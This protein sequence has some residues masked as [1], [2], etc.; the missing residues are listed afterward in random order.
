MRIVDERVRTAEIQDGAVLNAK[1]GA[2]A[3]IVY[4][5]LNL[6]TSI[7]TGDIAAGAVTEPK[8]E[9]ATSN[10][11][12][13]Y[14][15]ARFIYDWNTDGG[16][17]GSIPFRGDALPAKSIIKG[18]R[19]YV[20][21]ALTGAGGTTAGIT[22]VG[23]DDIVPDAAVAGAPWNAATTERAITPVDTLISDVVWAAGG[24]PNL[25]VTTHNL[26]DGAIDLWLEYIVND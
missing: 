9:P 4:S 21:R 17:A 14:R 10:K 13:A 2:T 24:I 12:N 22:A 26:T 25:V 16:V 7:A 18:G 1:V 3:A 19:M 15:V 5:K 6:A 11:R 20:I 8:L 23:A